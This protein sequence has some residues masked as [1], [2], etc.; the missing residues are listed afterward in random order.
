M[1]RSLAALKD[2][3]ASTFRAAFVR[4]SLVLLPAAFIAASAS[5]CVSRTVYV[6]DDRNNDPA[7]VV[8][9]REPERVVVE[10]RPRNSGVVAY[11]SDAGIVDDSDFYEPLSPYG[12]WIAY[13][14]YG[15][16]WQPS[17]TV[18]GAGFRPYTHGHWEHTE[19]GWT[20]VD[21]HPFGWATG[22]YGRWLY[23]SSY[24]WVWTPGTV[25]SP[26]WVT[27]RTGGGYVGWAAMPPGSVYGGSYS[28]YD[29]SWVFVSSG[30]MGVTYVGGVIV[31]GSRYRSCYTSTYD[32]RDTYVVYGRDY[33]RGP[34]YDDVRRQGR[35]IHR[36]LE[37]TERDR[38]VTR[39]P[40]G[41][42][43]AR[44]RD[45]DRDPTTNGRDR[46]DNGRG[47]SGN[48]GGGGSANNGGRGRDRDTGSS[49]DNCGGSGREGCGDD[50]GTG[51]TGGNSSNGSSGRGR[52]RGNTGTDTDRDDNYGRDGS[53]R[54][55]NG[56]VAPESS[57][58]DN[59]RGIPVDVNG[60]G[61]D[62]D[63][64][65]GRDDNGRG[66]APV[67]VRD[68]RPSSLDERAPTIPSTPITRRPNP[69]DD[70]RVPVTTPVTPPER[71][72]DGDNDG[73]TDRNDLIRQPRVTPPSKT[74]V[75]D[76]ERFRDNTATTPRP[77]TSDRIPSRSPGVD[78][79]P[80][81]SPT[82]TTPTPSRPRGVTRAPTAPPATVAPTAPTT[83]EEAT[84][85]SK[86]KKATTSSKAKPRKH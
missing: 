25:W 76:P 26:A 49:V 45:R 21:H 80:A 42:V 29:T 44:G 48:N 41:T 47:G 62:R 71:G 28:V 27:W 77:I 64:T 2:L 39:P 38:P 3:T 35:V 53:G 19:Y 59:V 86:K 79:A 65:D 8:Q 14:G 34:D 10:S 22:H 72:D 75:D 56:R 5:G 33:Y 40:A 17:V 73:R 51:G 78:R 66:T 20:W 81:R 70:D 83:T 13:P 24:G 68:D 82:P 46:D 57:P 43:I 36:P 37:E 16:V 67:P 7:P 85:P 84:P 12:T 15:R 32:Y 50:R 1:F 69:R 74:L 23:D 60:R 61:R 31:T 63:D 18:V 55:D 58:S 52:D 54:D 9:Q 6:V 4:R 30:N 11:E